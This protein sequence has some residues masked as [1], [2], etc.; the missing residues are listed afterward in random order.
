[1]KLNIV[2]AATGFQWVKL[3]FRTFL[4]QPLALAALVFLYATL[5]LAL[6]VLP[7]VGPFLACALVPVATLGLMAATRVAQE[8]AFPMPTV[9]FTGLRA[10]RE[11]VRSMLALGALYA[12]SIFALA[13]VVALVVPMSVEGKTTVDIAQSD[14]F[15]FRVMLTALFYMPFSLAFWHAP[16]LVH[17]HGVPAG[18][19]LFF[20]FV[21]CIRNLRAFAAYGLGW[22]GVGLAVLAA[23]AI[24]AAV[25]PWLA[26]VVFGATSTI[27]TIAFYISLYFTFRDSFLA[28]EDNTGDTP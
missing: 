23:T 4:K 3:G 8:S 27:A 15:R 2:P 26:A 18:K 17:W 21:A 10:S 20:S 12:A 9:L 16:A 28:A 5:G 1:M 22:I 6:L 7:F 24:A 14:E 11:R 19:S 25:S 13:V